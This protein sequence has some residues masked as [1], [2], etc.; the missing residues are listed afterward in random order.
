MNPESTP[1]S[2]VRQSS[3]RLW[4]V[5][6][7][8]E[9]SIEAL[10]S[11][12]GLYRSLSKHLDLRLDPNDPEFLLCSIFGHRHNRYHCPK[13]LFVG[14]NVFPDFR[15]YD[16]AFSFDPTKG[17][18]FRL[19]LWAIQLGDPSALLRP[20]EDPAGLL[21]SKERF[22]AFVYSN[23]GCKQRNEFFQALSSKKQVDAAGRLFNNTGGLSDR[24]DASAFS[25]L[26]GFYS[27]YKFA[28]AF[29]NS[30][31]MGYTTEKIAAPLLGGCVP[32][33]WGNPEIAEEF[34]PDAF[35][36]AHDF[37]SLEDLANYVLKVDADDDL[38]LRYLSA[39]RFAD[40]KLPDDADWEVLAD[41][42]GKIFSQK[43]D[44][45]SEIN[46]AKRDYLTFTP[47]LI[48]R[49]LRKMKKRKLKRTHTRS[50]NPSIDI[51]QSD[52]PDRV[53]ASSTSIGADTR[54][55]T[56]R[57]WF[58]DFWGDDYGL[59]LQ[60]ALSRRFD[61]HLDPINPE[62]LLCGYHGRQHAR[63]ACTKVLFSQENHFPDFRVYDWAFSSDPT[64]GRNFRLPVWSMWMGDPSTLG[65][66]PLLQPI[67]DP[68][69]LLKRKERFCAF[70]YTNAKC[71]WRNEFFRV[72]SS[73][74]H[75]DAAGRLFNNTDRLT[76]RWDLGA[77]DDLPSFYSS[78][79]FTIAFEN[80]SSPGYTTEKLTAPLLGG[81]VPIYWGNP[82]ITEEFN[83]SAF[84]DAR[85]FSSLEDLAN[86]VLKVDMDDDLYLQYLSAPR[87][88]ENALPEDANWEIIADRM[89]HIFSQQI[90]PASKKGIA[91]LST[92]IHS[93]VLRKM[94]KFTNNKLRRPS[95]KMC[96]PTLSKSSK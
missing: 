25:D 79:K 92:R 96:N 8:H 75:V 44:P 59:H 35:I 81:S 13:I 52:I 77:F 76:D 3:P 78:Y 15:T 49:Q 41:R 95:H 32:I 70:V 82:E 16:W 62:F 90:V 26:P 2:D 28:V 40:N 33:Y 83:P 30:S 27:R 56:P 7:G 9:E 94:N 74:K 37:G 19:P 50:L 18:N 48:Q 36:N 89:E 17:R 84:I 22:C 51:G 67:K 88:R 31:S 1:A 46:L 54:R 53:R 45:I 11:A 57:L 23:P 73:K 68:A 63:Y 60:S 61:L 20:V 93:F 5:D 10:E 71:K 42:L 72:L 80:S 6:F 65:P 85:D 4:F 47:S 55:S 86:Y 14:K 69:G 66:Y 38:Y 21:K 64:G 24:N 43:V 29:E 87:F 12:S 58:I 34:N 39:R 91:R